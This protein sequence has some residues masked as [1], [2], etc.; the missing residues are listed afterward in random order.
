MALRTASQ[1]SAPT[2]E[3]PAGEHGAAALGDWA[4]SP[5]ATAQPS[6]E[7]ARDERNV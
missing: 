5:I 7:E 2:V 4:H 6:G 1:A 3:V